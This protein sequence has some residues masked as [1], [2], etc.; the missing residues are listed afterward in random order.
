M[1]S[2]FL[3]KIESMVAIFLLLLSLYFISTTSFDE[4]MDRQWGLFKWIFLLSTLLF[5]ISDKA[6]ERVDAK[7][8]ILQLFFYS[9]FGAL[10]GGILPVGSTFLYT[11]QEKNSQTFAS[12]LD[13]I[14]LYRFLVVLVVV[15][16]FQKL[17]SKS[18]S[19]QKQ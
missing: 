10:V 9:F 7:T 5:V 15:M 14:T 2:P 18:K 3:K 12:Y 8:H 1:F 4:F 6:L 16:I 11:E 17:L 19:P 13:A